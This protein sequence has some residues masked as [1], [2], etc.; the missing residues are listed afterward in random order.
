MSP[1]DP[2]QVSPL[3]TTASNDPQKHALHAP[4]EELSAGFGEQPQEPPIPD[5]AH[6][7]T[8]MGF[9]QNEYVT[10]IVSLP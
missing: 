9:K 7:G 6:G 2:S 5:R 4:R 3:L 8:W 1:D 10:D